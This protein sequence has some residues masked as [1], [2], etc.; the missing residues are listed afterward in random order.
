MENNEI[1]LKTA[2]K[3]IEFLKERLAIIRQENIDEINALRA[4][5][6][7]LKSENEKIREQLDSILYSRSYKFVQKLKKI[8][9][10]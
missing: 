5:N 4:E 2:E 9:R 1:L 7:M 3:E 8:I 10:K 6:K